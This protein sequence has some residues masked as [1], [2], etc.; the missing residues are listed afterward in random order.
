MNGTFLPLAEARVPVTDR[1]LLFGD[2]VYEVIPVYRGNPFRLDAH[3]RRL[4]RSLAAI[5]IPNPH[6]DAGWR[7][8]FR[9]LIERN[10]GGDL[11]L[12]LQVTRG[13]YPR[14]DHRLPPDPRPTVIAFCQSRPGADPDTFES[15]VSA[16][17]QP[18]IRWAR[19]E[20]KSTALLP[21]VLLAAEA[22]DAGANEAILV[23][24]GHVTEGSSSN[25][26]VVRDG[27]VATPPLAP[28][29]LAGIT[30]EAV[31]EVARA[32]AVPC[33]ERDIAADELAAA[34]EI[35]LTSSTR[36]I[37]PVTTLD[38]VPVGDG[39]PGPVWTRMR[40]LLQADLD[41]PD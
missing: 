2:A 11:S 19:C 17:V 3:L 13:A 8:L 10:G 32:H 37:Y 4:A 7:A 22:H 29:I 28:S 15:G 39:R 23:R 25:V 24:D 35:W 1:G 5:R 6:D 26:F 41:E 27:T 9:E 14:R 40:A 38:G 33:A 30:R 16:V 36:E 20:I 18:D 21:N 12:Y 31:L 34:D